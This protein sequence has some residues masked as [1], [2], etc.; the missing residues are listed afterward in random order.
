MEEKTPAVRCSAVRT[1]AATVPLAWP[2]NL[3]DTKQRD[4]SKAG[5]ATE[6]HSFLAAER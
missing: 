2:R 4:G 1:E 3:G 5:D 6:R